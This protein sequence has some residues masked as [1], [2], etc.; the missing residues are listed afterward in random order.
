ME[1]WHQRNDLNNSCFQ[2]LHVSKWVSKRRWCFSFASGGGEKGNSI[3]SLCCVLLP[4]LQL[5]SPSSWAFQNLIDWFLPSPLLSFSTKHTYTYPADDM[6]DRAVQYRRMVQ[7]ADTGYSGPTVRGSL[8]TY[9]TY[10]PT[11]IHQKTPS[12]S[13]SPLLCVSCW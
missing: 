1:S 13:S 11:Y 5:E 4:F 2:N 9:L 7:Y 3:S 6:S 12:F 10:L 8:P